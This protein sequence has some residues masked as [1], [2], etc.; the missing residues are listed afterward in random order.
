MSMKNFLGI[1]EAEY[2]GLLFI[3]AI[4]S[5]IGVLAYDAAVGVQSFYLTYGMATAG[6]F[7]A[8]VTVYVFIEEL[9]SLEFS[10]L[11]R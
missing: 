4:W 10:V 6:F 7:L 11:S 8:E 1:T 2:I 3:S 9:E 5:L